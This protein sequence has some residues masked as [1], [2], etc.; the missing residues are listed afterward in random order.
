MTNIVINGNAYS[1]DGTAARDMR[2]G[3]HRLWLLPLAG[4]VATVGAA[5]SASAAAA[6]ASAAAA[7]SS[8]ANLVGTSASSVAI[9]T[10]SKSFTASTGRQWGVGQYLIAVDAANPANT[11]NGQITAYNSGTGALTINVTAST[12]GGTISSWNIYVSGTPG[13]TGSTG[14]TGASGASLPRMAVSSNTA[15][16]AVDNGKLIDA[17]GTIT[18]TFA[19]PATLAANWGTWVRNAGTGDVTLAHTSGN[20]DGL[21][22]FVLY[23]G[24][25]RLV[26]C[27]GSTIRTVP[28]VGGSRQ[29]TASGTYVVPPGLAGLRV[30]G[31]GSGAS[32]GRGA[33][34]APGVS[35]DGGPGGGGG[36]TLERFLTGIAAGTSV[37]VTVPAA[38]N[39]TAAA[40]TDNAAATTGSDG[41]DASFGTYLVALGGKANATGGS[42][43]TTVNTCADPGG[44]PTDT[45]LNSVIWLAGRLFQTRTAAQ[46]CATEWAGG[47]GGNGHDTTSARAGRRSLQ[48][49]GGGGGGGS[50]SNSDVGQ[51]GG[52]GGG[53][54]QSAG[55]V[56]T[57]VGLGGAGG[58][59]GTAGTAGST[60]VDS[61]AGD[62]GGGGGAGV[63][64]AAGAGANGA[65]PGGGGGGGGASRNGFASGGGGQGARGEI[66]VVE[67]L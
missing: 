20:I 13:P 5:A 22:S 63:A 25:V 52:A 3:G 1:D 62:G 66:F 9:G 42:V 43:L 54:G 40:T 23:P 26:Q 14:S 10:G 32:G 45:G 15:I 11:M 55:A 49:G 61:D 48:G 27:D 8:A 28:L 59:L 6:S 67:V 33:R 60:R 19:A 7:A 16:G 57:Y 47:A 58:A 39:G 65:A 37:T 51:A 34:Q 36:E 38:V 41:G 50:I 30:R 17:S 46:G 56:T 64:A 44:L 35:T 53:T 29:Y 2:Q 18:L 31:T 24:A 12:G 4:D 21:T